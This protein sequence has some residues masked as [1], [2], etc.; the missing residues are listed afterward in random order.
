MDRIKGISGVDN[1]QRLCATPYS[2]RFTSV[3]L[4]NKLSQQKAAEISQTSR[5]TIK[6]CSTGKDREV[7]N[8]PNKSMSK[9]IEN[10][11]NAELEYSTTL[12]WILDG[13]KS[14]IDECILSIAEELFDKST[15]TLE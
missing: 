7:M 13:D 9:A 14:N 11:C 8:T 6:R 3:L 10:L 2:V 4:A 1:R 15:L 12:S 5:G